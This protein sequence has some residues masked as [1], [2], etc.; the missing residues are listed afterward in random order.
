[1]DAHVHIAL[2]GLFNR[3]SWKA[4]P[5]ER[6]TQ[7]IREI[8]KQ[9]KM[10]NISILRDGG[11]GIFA[12]RLAREIA[13]SEGIIYK[14]PIYALYRKGFYGSFLG[15]PVDGLDSFKEEFKSLLEYR[16]DH[17]KIVLTGIVNFEKYGDVGAT[18]FTLDEMKYMVEWAKDCGLPVMVHANGRE[19]VG[20]AVKAGVNT[21]E[22]GYLISEAELYGMAERGI[23]WVPTLAPLGNI[24]A[25]EDGR[26]EKERE[27]IQRVYEGQ[28]ENLK[29]ALEIGVKVALGSDA[30]A[31][32][33][34]H[35]SGL[36]DEVEHFERAGLK[37]GDIERMCLENGAKALQLKD[38]EINPGIIR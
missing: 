13:P 26:F 16:P 7:W 1:M 18:T 35:G 10:R 3:R 15:K 32:L 2:N 29:K 25:S 11:D 33:V 12:S 21:I 38:F 23:V 31:Y 4:S 6:K 9:Y 28:V 8:F 5:I 19:G 22:H 14:S 20:R 34:G 30:G 17:L 27:V 24:L 36:L 37:R